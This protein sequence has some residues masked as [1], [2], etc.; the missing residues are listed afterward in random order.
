MFYVVNKFRPLTKTPDLAVEV[1]REIEAASGLKFTA[2]INNSNLGRE[3]TPE[4]VLSSVEYAEQIAKQT[5]LPIVY[6][7]VFKELFEP[8]KSK[9][10]NLYPIGLQKKL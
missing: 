5:N 6:T 7:T 9:I 2:I 1:M 8:L 3:T 4:D 10:N